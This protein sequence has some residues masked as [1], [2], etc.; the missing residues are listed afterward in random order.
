M[1]DTCLSKQSLLYT[2]QKSCQSSQ[3]GKR[4]SHNSKKDVSCQNI[5]QNKLFFCFFLVVPVFLNTEIGLN[6][7]KFYQV[8]VMDFKRQESDNH[9]KNVIL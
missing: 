2:Q 6:T 5:I 9:E 4:L 3:S 1:N 8:V 7:F